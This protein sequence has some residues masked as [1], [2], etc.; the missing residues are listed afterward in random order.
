MPNRIDVLEIVHDY[1]TRIDA[2]VRPCILIIHD[3]E[4]AR[5][6]LDLVSLTDYQRSKARDDVNRLRVRA[7]SAQRRA[8]NAHIVRQANPAAQ[9]DLDAGEHVRLIGVSVGSGQF[10]CLVRTLHHHF[11]RLHY[12]FQK[13]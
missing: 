4:D 7:E 5:I 3:A 12:V 8:L 11:V 13:K 10:E 6:A 9:H 1:R 2:S